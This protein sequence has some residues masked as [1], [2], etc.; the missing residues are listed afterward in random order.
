MAK[1]ALRAVFIQ[2]QR[3]AREAPRRLEGRERQGAAED[4]ATRGCRCT[5]RRGPTPGSRSA[6]RRTPPSSREPSA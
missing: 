5:A 3:P 2:G 6:D 4:P 1:G